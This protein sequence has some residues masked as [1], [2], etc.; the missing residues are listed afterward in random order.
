VYSF[1]VLS[2][3]YTKDNLTGKIKVVDKLV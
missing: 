2:K 1:S 3:W